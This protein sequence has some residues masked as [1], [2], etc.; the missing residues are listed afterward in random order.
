MC[1]QCN[2]QLWFQSFLFFFSLS[3][4]SVLLQMMTCGS[5]TRWGTFCKRNRQPSSDTDK[6]A[7]DSVATKGL[8]GSRGS[9]SKRTDKSEDIFKVA[10][11]RSRAALTLNCRNN[12][13]IYTVGSNGSVSCL[14]SGLLYKKLSN[15][16][17]FF[18]SSFHFNF[19]CFNFH[20][21]LL[22]NPLDN[23]TDFHKSRS[24]H[25]TCTK[26]LERMSAS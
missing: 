13:L 20:A 16:R 15:C 4:F 12:C 8:P 19:R 6:A 21:T 3:L 26:L 7:D 1:W 2:T 11:A 17:F 14:T 10:P 18:K 24:K 5:E 25:I 9:P 22:V 23:W